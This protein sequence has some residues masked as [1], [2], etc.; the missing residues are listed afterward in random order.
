MKLKFSQY[1]FFKNEIS[2]TGFKTW[3]WFTVYQIAYVVL[4]SATFSVEKCINSHLWNKM[5][6][7]RF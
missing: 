2:D 1:E 6:A 7:K 4:D 5:S 3:Y